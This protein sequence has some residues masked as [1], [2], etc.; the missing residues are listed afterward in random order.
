MCRLSMI[1][2]VNVVLNETVVVDRVLMLERSCSH[3]HQRNATQRCV[4]LKIVVANRPSP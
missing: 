2:L 3:S 4:V 1:L